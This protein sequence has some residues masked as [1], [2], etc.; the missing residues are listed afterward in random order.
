MTTT[1]KPT[2]VA[3]H[4]VTTRLTIK[5]IAEILQEVLGQRLTAHLAGLSDAKAIGAYARGEREPRVEVEARLRL[6]HQVLQI[7]VEADS[8]HVAR[9]W[10]IGQ[11]PQLDNDSPAE[12][13]REDR[14]K[15]V[16]SAANAFVRS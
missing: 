3:V 2:A 14:L 6:A 1:T 10:F 12:A 7:V 16:L 15:D 5:D 11:N 8:D 4:A 9:A 13:I